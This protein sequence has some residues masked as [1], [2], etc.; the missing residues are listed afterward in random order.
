MQSK[1]FYFSLVISLHILTCTTPILATNIVDS[2]LYD[3]IVVGGGVAGLSAM[4]SLAQ[5]GKVNTLLIEGGNRLGGRAYTI[6]FGSNGHIEL[7]AQ[8]ESFIHFNNFS[9][10]DR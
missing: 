8:V 7:G 6:P 1:F 9:L 4:S 2:N 5:G 10:L 3:V